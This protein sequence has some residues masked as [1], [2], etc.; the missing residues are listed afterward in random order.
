M[1]D[2]PAL[3]PL[4]VRLSRQYGQ[5]LQRILRLLNHFTADEMVGNFVHLEQFK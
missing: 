3:E 4:F 5:L 1:P 2:S